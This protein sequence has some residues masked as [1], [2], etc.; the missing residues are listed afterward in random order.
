MGLL[1]ILVGLGLLIW[2]AFRGWSV[3]LLAPLCALVAAAFGGA[4]LLASWTQIFMVSAAGFLAQFF[5]IFLLGA[6]FGKLMD[7][8]GA[9]AAVAG[10]ISERLGEKRVMLAVVLA[11]ALVTYGGVSLFVAFFVIV[12]MAQSLFRAADIPRRLVP[13]AVILGTSTFTMSALPGTPSIQNAIPMPFFGTT[14]FAA[15]GLGII[16]AIIML[17]VGLWWLG[18]AEN[19][20][21]RAGAGYGDAPAEAAASAVDDEL[22][23][24]RASTAREFDPAEMRHGHHSEA[25]VPV[26]NAL[27]PLIVVVVVNLAMSLAVLP[28]LDV[29]YLA[30]DKWGGTSLA[31]VAGVWSVVVALAAAIVTV[32]A[33]NRARLPQLR[34]T[35]DA[36]ANASVLPALSVASLV[37]FGAVVAALPAFAVVRDA[38]LGIGGGPLVSLAVATNLLAALTG[39]ASGGLTIALDALGQ[40][41]M[42]IAAHS[43]IDPG[44]MHRVAVIGSGTLDILPH[45]GA[46]VSLLAICGLTHRD[47]YRDIVMVGIVSSI[48]ALVAVIVIGGAV[49]SF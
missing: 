41:Y 16:A 48:A 34:R 11:G 31:A 9:V 24:E 36:G 25:A 28:R 29:A 30:E 4:P 39:S 15:P 26:L 19:A 35:M 1:G 5:P 17:G 8:S 3:L 37:G 40:T 14:P 46:V 33:C 43:G 6:V 21:R 49:G 27:L 47:S 7:D 22:V 44:L 20:A 13:A 38:V 45:N 42:D 2:L 12:P 18:R 23:R 10:F 32:I